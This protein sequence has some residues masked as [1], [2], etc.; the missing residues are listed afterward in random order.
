MWHLEIAICRSRHTLLHV[1]VLLCSF[2]FV[3]QSA[4]ISDRW[5]WN[6]LSSLILISDRYICSLIENI[7][8]HTCLCTTILVFSSASYAQCNIK[9]ISSS[10]SS[11][12]L[13]DPIWFVLQATSIGMSYTYKPGEN[14]WMFMLIDLCYVVVLTGISP[15]LYDWISL[16]CKTWGSSQAQLIGYICLWETEV[17][18]SKWYE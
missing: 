13:K 2:C 10:S 14:Y 9:N 4:S 18:D 11:S 7:L 16:W 15:S 17:K 3:H 5:N 1:L 6:P 8:N 12:L